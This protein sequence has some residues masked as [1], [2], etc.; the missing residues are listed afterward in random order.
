MRAVDRQARLAAIRGVPW[1]DRL[2]QLPKM[3]AMGRPPQTE[4]R[5]SVTDGRY[6]AVIAAV[7]VEP[8]GRAEALERV[9]VPGG[10]I[11]ERP[12]ERRRMMGSSA[13]RDLPFRAL[14]Q[15]PPP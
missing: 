3:A 14:N 11:E 15:T 6:G 9:G 7:Y 2:A 1:R 10:G 12:Y 8:A 13:L 4:A 5:P